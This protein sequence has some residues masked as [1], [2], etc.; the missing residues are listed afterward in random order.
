MYLKQKFSNI[1]VWIT[2][3]GVSPHDEEAGGRLMGFDKIPSI[4]P[5]TSL[6]AID[7]NLCIRKYQF[8]AFSA[9][10]ACP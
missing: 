9:K 3:F 6:K 8:R 2:K 1:T 4:V 7:R 5:Q 10:T